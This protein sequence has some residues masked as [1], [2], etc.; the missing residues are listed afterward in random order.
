MTDS[1][2]AVPAGRPVMVDLIDLAWPQ[3]LNA[4]SSAGSGVLYKSGCAVI[5]W[6]FSETSG[7]AVARAEL[8]D[9]SD[10]SGV[11][12]AAIGMVA[13]GGNNAGPGWPGILVRNSLYLNV[14]AGA[15]NGSVWVVPVVRGG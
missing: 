12:I 15:F 6:A 2:F 8:R 4:L 13:S 14:V 11:L 3:A 1:P 5:G 10:A 9:S 7:T